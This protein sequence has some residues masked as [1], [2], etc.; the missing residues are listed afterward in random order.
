MS[1]YVIRGIE[2]M[3]HGMYS[4]LIFQTLGL[5]APHWRH[6]LVSSLAN[7]FD[8]GLLIIPLFWLVAAAFIRAA[9]PYCY[10]SVACALVT[11]A[12]TFGYAAISPETRY[13]LP[14]IAPV[15]I[16]L[17]VSIRGVFDAIQW[18]F[19]H[20]SSVTLASEQAIP[21]TAARVGSHVSRIQVWPS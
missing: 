17:A 10:L 8:F 12:I 21:S 16:V 13:V 11:A 5:P 7:L 4:P 19:Q 14:S 1:K 3:R 9:R 15:F 20:N 2:E 6:P 18:A